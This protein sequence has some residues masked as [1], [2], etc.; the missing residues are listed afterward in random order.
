MKNIDQQRVTFL[1]KAHEA[2][3]RAEQSSDPQARAAWQ[4]VADGYSDLA[5]NVCPLISMIEACSALSD[6]HDAGP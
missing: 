1:A 3:A 6:A 2:H 5:H 4:L